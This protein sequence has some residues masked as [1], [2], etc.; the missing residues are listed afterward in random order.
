M[1]ICHA[2][3]CHL[4]VVLRFRIGAAHTVCV[5]GRVKRDEL[6]EAGW[7]GV[8]FQ[9]CST[10]IFIWIAPKFCIANCHWNCCSFVRFQYFP[11]YRDEILISNCQPIL[12]NLAC[13]GEPIII[14]LQSTTSSIDHIVCWAPKNQN[15]IEEA[16][17][18]LG[19]MEWLYWGLHTSWKTDGKSQ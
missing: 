9:S 6:G 15:V 2:C 7:V 18:R 17:F 12:A 5:I 1:R 4:S 8:G 10:H 11:R 19:F 14:L 3:E 13:F 16:V